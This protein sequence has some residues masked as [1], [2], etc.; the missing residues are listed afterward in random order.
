[1]SGM[2]DMVPRLDLTDTQERKVNRLLAEVLREIQTIT[3]EALYE[4]VDMQ[5]WIDD[6]EVPRDTIQV[7]YRRAWSDLEGWQRESWDDLAV[8]WR[9]LLSAHID[10]GRVA[11]VALDEGL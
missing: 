2:G 5:G 11:E 1:M 8:A 6:L 9:N 10:E 7:P 3:G 4:D